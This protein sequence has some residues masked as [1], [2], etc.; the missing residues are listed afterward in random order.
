MYSETEIANLALSHL[1]HGKELADIDTDV[2]AVPSALRR[3]Y[4]I[5]RKQ[6]FRAFPWSFARKFYTLNLVEE[7]P[8]TEWTYSYRYPSDCLA[9][10][11]ILS[12]TRR[13]NRETRIKYELASDDDGKLIYSDEAS[14]VGEYTRDIT[15]G[16][17]YS[18]DFVMAMSYRLAY[19]IAPR[20]AGIDA[21]SLR[22][23]MKAMFEEAIVEAQGMDLNEQSFDEEPEAENIRARL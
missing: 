7:N 4:D 6:T 23:E 5:A 10:R 11:K 13:D 17:F 18:E 21:A 3:F 1:G 16:Q 20:V 9:F 12:G 8:T 15:D 14:A 2:G 22:R 19:L